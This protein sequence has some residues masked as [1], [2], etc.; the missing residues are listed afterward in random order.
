VGLRAGGDEQN[1]FLGPEIE[2]R[3]FGRPTRIFVTI[4][5]AT[6]PLLPIIIIIIIL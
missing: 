4:L 5:T 6:P 1:L 3:F 2:L